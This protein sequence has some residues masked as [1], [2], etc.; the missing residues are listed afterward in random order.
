M[1]VRLS[2]AALRDL[3]EAVAFIATENPDAARRLRARLVEAADGLR[4]FPAMAQTD[5]RGRRIFS[6]PGTR[7]RLLYRVGEQT[8]VV[9]RILH[10]ARQWPPASS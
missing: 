2:T 8:V 6:V 5:G 3:S 1:P 10:G 9:L 7:F 4:E